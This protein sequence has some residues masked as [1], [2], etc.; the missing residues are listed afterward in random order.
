METIIS[1]LLILAQKERYGL[2][3][4]RIRKKVKEYKR[5]EK[6]YKKGEKE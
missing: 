2:G 3:G 5:G 1:L 6:E 4:E